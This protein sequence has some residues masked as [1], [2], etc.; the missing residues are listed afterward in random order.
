MKKVTMFVIVSMVIA[1]SVMFMSTAVFAGNLQIILPPKDVV[2]AG[3]VVTIQ[4]VYTGGKAPEL[5]MRVSEGVL[6][7]LEQHGNVISATWFTP[8][9]P[10]NMPVIS[11]LTWD[12]SVKVQKTVILD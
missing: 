9:Q 10:G 7:P 6:G 2:P 11:A 3:E 12:G 4:A 8:N 1:V 5:D